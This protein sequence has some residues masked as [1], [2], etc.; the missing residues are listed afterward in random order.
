MAVII[1]AVV[2][3]EKFIQTEAFRFEQAFKKETDCVA[4]AVFGALLV[5]EMGEFRKPQC[6]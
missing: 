4:G 6:Q 1:G 2:E 5:G 3:V